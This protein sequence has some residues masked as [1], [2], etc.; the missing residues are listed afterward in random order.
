MTT[1]KELF[2][3]H[4]HIG[5]RSDKWNPKMV[6]FIHTKKNRV[7][8]FDLEQTKD[9][10]EKA[11]SFLE[12]IKKKNGKVLFVGTKPQT[13]FVLQNIMKDLNEKKF[14]Y[15]D[16]KWAP[17]LLTNFNEIRKRA[18]YYLNL[19]SQ[20]ESGEIN[21]YTKKEVAKFKKELEKLDASYHGVAEMRQKPDVVVVLDC[22]G[23]RLA[24]EEAVVSKIPVVGIVDT[25]ADP[26]K[27][28]YVI[29][30][31]DDSVKAIRYAAKTL[32]AALD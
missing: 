3:N 10:F 31:N 22:V 1:I 12:T 5:H 23:N 7:H 6:N 14:F 19:K 30:A 13:A 20:F 21:K 26:D 9:A 18:D 17:G 32:I 8:L 11:V 25:N 28:D 24:I 4:L 29:P 16:K 2:E 15:V 27:I